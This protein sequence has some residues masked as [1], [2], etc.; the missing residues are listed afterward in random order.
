MTIPK[1]GIFS[2]LF[3]EP[4]PDDLAA[5]I[6]ASGF[7][8]TQL[9]MSSL[10]LPPL[11]LSVEDSALEAVRAAFDQHGV[12][13]SAV[14]GTYNMV[15]PNSDEV[16]RGRAGFETVA[17]ACGRLGAGVITLC[18]GTL[19]PD[20][21][22]RYHPHNSSAVAW[23]TLLA[24]M[25]KLIAIAD[26]YDLVLGIEP[27]PSNIIS[28]A[29]LALQLLIALPSPRLKIVFD[30]ANL[31]RGDAEGMRRLLVRDVGLLAGVTAIFHA[32]NRTRNGTPSRPADGAVDIGWL[33]GNMIER[34]FDGPVIAHG[35]PREDA[36]S[37]A[38]FLSDVLG[39][40]DGNL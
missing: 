20:D 3:S 12:E 35:F 29:D 10:G 4:S 31:A 16:E 24:E 13:I 19:D 37:T 40:G 32:Q 25:E 23:Q 27:E 17:A 6:R 2:K 34:G 1:V 26:K 7:T 38:A 5:A 8:C 22:W 28:S 21:Q 30:P 33:L 15:H 9:N 36:T 39:A 11:P 14:S 18:T